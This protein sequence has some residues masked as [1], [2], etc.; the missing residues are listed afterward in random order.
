MYL[1][2]NCTWLEE[3]GGRGLGRKKNNFLKIFDLDKKTINAQ[4][5]IQKEWK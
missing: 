3:S 2:I 1:L 4:F 5:L